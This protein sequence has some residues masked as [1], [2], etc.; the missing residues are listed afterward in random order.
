M[1]QADPEHT[2]S[3]ARVQM[4]PAEAED[5]VA[6]QRRAAR[7]ERYTQK[8]KRKRVCLAELLDKGGDKQFRPLLNSLLKGQFN[9]NG[10]CRV[11]WLHP[12]SPQPVADANPTGIC[13]RWSWSGRRKSETMRELAVAVCSKLTTFEN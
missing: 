13:G 7:I 10:R 5:H 9:S 12:R 3:A 6:C 4:P 8:T 11:L 1:A 2:H